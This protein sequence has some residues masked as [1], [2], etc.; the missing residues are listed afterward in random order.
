M[1]LSFHDSAA[2]F[3]SYKKDALI[4]AL[5]VKADVQALEGDRRAVSG[6]S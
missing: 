5:L 3:L 2:R 6:K 4:A 1:S